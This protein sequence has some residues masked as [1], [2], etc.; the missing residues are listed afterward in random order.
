MKEL[1][2][3]QS[4]KVEY[5]NDYIQIELCDYG[6]NYYE[7]WSESNLF[8]DNNYGKI[9]DLNEAKELFAQVVNEFNDNYKD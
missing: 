1:N 3:I 9:F 2:I 7:I 8:E 5:D 4:K 6:D